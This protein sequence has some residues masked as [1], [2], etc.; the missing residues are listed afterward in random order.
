MRASILPLSFAAVIGLLATSLFAQAQYV[1]YRPPAYV[2]NPY[3]YAYRSPA[4]VVYRGNYATYSPTY[5]TYSSVNY[6]PA[7]S[8]YGYAYAQPVVTTAGYYTPG[9]ARSYLS[10]YPVTPFTPSWFQWSY[11]P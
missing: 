7:V 1:R 4:A 3:G 10:P 6:Y 11:A 8:P 5:S 9:F 2:A